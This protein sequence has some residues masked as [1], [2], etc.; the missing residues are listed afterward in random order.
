LVNARSALFDLYGD[1]LVSRGGQAPVAALVRCLGALS[2]A[3]PAVRTAV[4]RMVRQGWL[5]A[6]RTGLGPGYAMT[7]R[8]EH[9]LTEAATRIY[10]SI[11]AAWDGSWHLVTLPRI[12]ERSRRDRVR[13]GLRYLGY[14]PI[15]DTTWVAARPS[16]ELDGLLATE[17]VHAERFA[18]RH[19]GDSQALVRQVWDLDSLAD[20]YRLWMVGARELIE[21][22]RSSA[23]DEEAFTARSNLVH[24]WRKF[25]FIDPQLPDELLP[26]NWIGRRAAQ[27]F[28]DRA[29]RLLPA[30][31]RFIDRCLADNGRRNHE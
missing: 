15:D 20:E 17:G 9:R 24:E 28:D 29:A 10:R 1:H 8:A 5:A 30:T 7:P 21:P 4:S 27:Y 25:L 14:G 16:S 13:Q 3:A 26:A 2:I 11:D 23:S 22:I 12:A 19:E 31:D 6:V 18:A